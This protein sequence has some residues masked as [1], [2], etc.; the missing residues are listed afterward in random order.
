MPVATSTRPC[1]ICGQ[2]IDPERLEAVRDTRLCGDHARQIAKYGGEFRISASHDRTSKPGS[3]RQNDG[4]VT[5][6]QN[7]A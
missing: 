6:Q 2:P 4:G 1:E 3:L 5:T 7:D